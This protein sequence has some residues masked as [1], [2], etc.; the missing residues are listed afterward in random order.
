[1]AVGVCGELGADLDG[2]DL[3]LLGE[4][5]QDGGQRV[6]DGGQ[7]GGVSGDAAGRGGEAG[8]QDG[9]AAVADAGQPFAEP[10]G[11]EPVG[12]VLGG[13]WRLGRL[14][15]VRGQIVVSSCG[16]G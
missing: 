9:V 3:D 1:V 13:A 7:G 8:V 11:V 14:V 12:A 4:G 16:V 15:T 5:D 2:Q 10:G 6:G